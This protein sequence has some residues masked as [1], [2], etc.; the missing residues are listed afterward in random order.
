MQGAP[1]TWANVTPTNAGLNPG[2]FGIQ[3]MMG[4]PA[5]PGTFY[6]T[7][8]ATPGVFKSTDFGRTWSKISSASLT[9]GCASDPNPNRDPATPMLM[10]CAGTYGYGAARSI[11]NGVTWT[12]HVTDNA[13]AGTFSNDPYAFDID[14]YDN[15]H[16]I[17]GF[18][19][20]P[21][22]SE[23]T[24]GGQTWT[25]ITSAGVAQ[26]TSNFPFFIDTG[27]AT[28]TRGNWLIISQWGDGTNGGIHRTTNGGGMWSRTSTLQHGHGN[29]QIFQAGAGVLYAA[30]YDGS[31]GHGIYRSPDYGMT[32]Q[33]V[34]DGA[35]NG[36][37]GTPSSLYA[38]NGWASAGGQAQN[39]M[40]APRATGT[41]GTW[42][43][44]D[45]STTMSNGSGHAAVAFDASVNRW[46]IVIGA[47]TAGIWRYEEP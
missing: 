30:G 32:W 17:A 41:L 9:Y 42:Q 22:I 35:Q 47:W 8:S 43:R 25:T 38:D 26:G 7:S 1:G 28:T 3:T 20:T 31:A 36:V 24:N 18:H 2:Q 46:V 21:G 39:L 40:R 16:V 11:D 5:R 33:K 29:A 15:Q 19:G 6:F 12:K 34:A 27:N 37:F 45:V 44:Y 23:S 13:V 10:I 14:P 4:D